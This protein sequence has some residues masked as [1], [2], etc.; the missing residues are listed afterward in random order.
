MSLGA[1]VVVAIP[2]RDEHKTIHQTLLGVRR[3]LERARELGLVGR[4]TVVVGAHRCTDQTAHV[5]RT[6]LAGWGDVFE[7]GLS[8]SVGTVR[9]RAVRRGITKLRTPPENSWVLSTDADTTVGRNWVRDVLTQATMHEAV[10]VVGLAQLDRWRGSPAGEESY[11]RL[12]ASGMQDGTGLHQHDHV[13]GAN[14][15]VRLDA[16]L[17]CGGFP[18]VPHAE[19][20]QL[21]DLLH[22][23]GH[24]L[25]RTRHVAVQTSGRFRGRAAN[26]LADR[27]RHLDEEAARHWAQEARPPA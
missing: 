27:L 18:H 7:D 20:Q 1:G 25:L 9:D 16:Y 21:V 5:C 3:A 11:E 10:A 2:A 12:V 23:R 19:D 13:Y 4:A 22:A 8:E 15:A 14:L 6:A 17:D 26:G 24:R